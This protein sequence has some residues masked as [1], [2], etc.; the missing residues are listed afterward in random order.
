MKPFKIS[1]KPLF[2]EHYGN[3]QFEEGLGSHLSSTLLAKAKDYDI[4]IICIGTDRSTGDALGPLIGT[5][6]SS[7]NLDHI[8]IYGTLDSPVHALNLT[9]I[10]SHI[11]RTYDRPFIVAIDACL[12][13]YKN[14]GVVTLAQ[15]PLKP[16]AAMNKKLPEVGHIHITGIVNTGGFLDY[17]VLQNTRL[18]FVM[19]MAES[20]STSIGHCHKD[21][22]QSRM[23]SAY[24]SS[25]NHSDYMS[26]T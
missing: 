6:L 9:D 11:K 19:A 17:F 4:V 15:G 8:T 16:G 2:R 21:I 23:L 5:K 10:L 12:G 7:L 14:V 26:L 20:I 18:S 25:L 3:F 13:E 1:R 24:H 22:K